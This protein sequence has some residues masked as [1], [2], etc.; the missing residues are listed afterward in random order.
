MANHILG[1]YN[2]NQS[3]MFRFNHW[4]PLTGIFTLD[5]ELED[6]YFSN[7]KP[8]TKQTYIKWNKAWQVLS[9]GLIADYFSNGPVTNLV[10]V[11]IKYFN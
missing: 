9:C 6:Q 3:K 8:S 5:D 2:N 7:V 11:A 1:N 4:I 10:E